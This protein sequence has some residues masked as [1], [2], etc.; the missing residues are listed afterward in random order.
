VDVQSRCSETALWP[1]HRRLRALRRG[2]GFFQGGVD[3]VLEVLQ[4]CAAADGVA[5]DEKN[6]V[7]STPSGCLPGGLVDLGLK[8]WVSR[9]LVILGRRVQLRGFGY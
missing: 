6:G 8:R 1:L 9:S 4:A 7:P 5:V 2:G 3:Q